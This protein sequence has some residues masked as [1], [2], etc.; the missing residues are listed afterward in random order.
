MRIPCAVIFGIALLSPAHAWADVKTQER[1]LIKFEGAIGRMVNIF[2]GKGARE[3]VVSTVALK[4]DRLLTI[5]GDAGEIIDLKEEKVY[6]LDLKGKSYTVMTFA[7][8]RRRME[9]EMA[10][11]QKEAGAAKPAP[12]PEPEPTQPG[13]TEP[14]K[15]Y[16]VDFTITNG[17]GARQIAGLPT[18]ESIATVVV[19]EKGKTIEQGGLVLETH[20]WMT[21][22]VPELQELNAFRQR[23]A[24]K[25]YGPV[26][27]QAAAAAAAGA[28][29][30]MAQAMAMYPQMKDAM[31][32]MA[33]EGKKLNGTPLF[34]E[35]I[36]QAAVPPNADG[37]E[38]QKAEP[39]AGLGGLLGGL[40][41]LRKKNPEAPAAASAP[42]VPGRTTVLT[43]TIET[44]QLTPS[45][46]EADVALPAGLKLKQ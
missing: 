14:K 39:P 42:A 25:I 44:L 13:A 46:T 38:A 22:S 31:A 24:E 28:G 32:K 2:G 23:Y 5:T 16:E 10:K 30:S 35:M 27:M 40:G 45:A 41:R 15:E 33:E 37:A 4:G 21:P 1:T 29:A 8:M 19:R 17:S 7:E 34:T 43:T 20:L 12:E 11:A 3:G 6:D 36:V 18:K 26:M 9:E